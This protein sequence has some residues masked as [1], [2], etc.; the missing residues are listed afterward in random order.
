MLYIKKKNRNVSIEM[1]HHSFILSISLL[2]IGFTCFAS[3]LFFFKSRNTPEPSSQASSS[4]LT[5]TGNPISM[6]PYVTVPPSTSSVPMITETVDEEGNTYVGQ[7]D[8][9]GKKHGYGVFTFFN[10]LM[11]YSGRWDKNYMSGYGEMVWA[12]KHRY[13]G[14]WRAG[15]RSGYGIMIW[16]SGNRYQGES[17]VYDSTFL[18]IECQ[19]DSRVFFSCILMFIDCLGNWV[20]DKRQGQ[21]IQTQPNGQKQSGKWYNDNF[22]G[23]DVQTQ[24]YADDVSFTGK[25]EKNIL[26]ETEQ[27]SE[28]NDR[29]VNL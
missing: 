23:N 4:P 8:S 24:R 29:A 25:D 28:T 6:K 7:I 21:G 12:D 14:Y 18:D 2:L 27:Q 10:G 22:I 13:I 26:N 3:G 1:H 17:F 20:R 16:P 5:T 15:Q 11:K 9:T 19:E